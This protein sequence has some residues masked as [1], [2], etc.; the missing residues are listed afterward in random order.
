MKLF[1]EATRLLQEMSLKN[2]KPDVVSYGIIIDSYSHL[3]EKYRAWKLFY[4]MEQK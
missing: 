3:G 1:D 2:I 4:E